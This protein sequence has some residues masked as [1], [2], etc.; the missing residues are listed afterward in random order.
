MTT[1]IPNEI[2]VAADGRLDVASLPGKPTV[3]KAGGDKPE[4]LPEV[5][6]GERILATPSRVG[7]RL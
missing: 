7:E 6:F 2:V 1:P 5:D 3:I 4:I